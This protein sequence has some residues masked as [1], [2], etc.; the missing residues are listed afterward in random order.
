MKREY[1]VYA[2][3]Y[4]REGNGI[5]SAKRSALAGATFAFGFVSEC[6]QKRPMN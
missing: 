3:G 2:V 6:K 5:I 4:V 1:T